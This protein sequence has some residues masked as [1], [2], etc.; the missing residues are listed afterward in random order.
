MSCPARLEQHVVGYVKQLLF[1]EP[2][3]HYHTINA[4]TACA[5]WIEAVVTTVVT[6]VPMSEPCTGGKGR[7][8]AGYCTANIQD[9]KIRENIRELVLL[10]VG[11]GRPI[12]DS[13]KI[14]E[15][16]CS[17]WSLQEIVCA[18]RSTHYLSLSRLCIA[19]RTL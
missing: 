9:F 2:V 18:L 17:A 15:T 19:D 5:L 16:E 12:V 3:V 14:S 6:V 8:S 11:H 4:A 1:E 7:G 10:L 13:D